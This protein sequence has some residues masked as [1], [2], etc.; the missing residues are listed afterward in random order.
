MLLGSKG[1][2]CEFGPDRN[3]KKKLAYAEKTKDDEDIKRRVLTQST[4]KVNC[5]AQISL[6]E[7]LKF[8]EYP[9]EADTTYCRN[10][11][12]AEL[13]KK[14]SERQKML[15]E[16][17]IYVVLPPAG[18]HSGHTVAEVDYAHALQADVDDEEDHSTIAM[19]AVLQPP[20]W[21]SIWNAISDDQ[22]KGW[23]YTLEDAERVRESFERHTGHTYVVEKRTK[24]FGQLKMQQVIQTDMKALKIRFKDIRD[25]VI[26]YD[27]VPFLVCGQYT[28]N[29]RFGRDRHKARKQREREREEERLRKSDNPNKKKRKRQISIKQGCQAKIEMKEIIRFQKFQCPPHSHH[30]RKNISLKIRD[31]WSAGIPLHIESRIYIRLPLK[32]E[33]QGSHVYEKKQTRARIMQAVTLESIEEAALR[34]KGHIHM[35]PVMTCGMLDSRAQGRKLFFKC[36]LL[37]KTGSFKIRGALNAVVKLKES[38]PEEEIKVVTHSSGNFGQALAYAAKLNGIEA[39]IVMPTT[40]PLCKRNA[41]LGYGAGVVMCEPTEE[42]REEFGKRVVE[43]TGA[44]FFS[45]SQTYDVISG[46]GTIGLELLEQIPDLD[47][48]VVPVGGGGM[49]AGIATAIKSKKPSIKVYAAEPANANDC[50]KSFHAKKFIPLPPGPV[51]TVADGLKVSIGKSTWPIIANYVDDVF[52]VTEEEIVNATCLVWQYMKQWIEPS[53]GVGVAV[54]MSENF[55]LLPPEIKNVAVILCGGNV[56]MDTV[57]SWL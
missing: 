56:D 49:I 22:L 13:R 37:Q 47:A 38:R 52:T 33:H 43:E 26:P 30:K 45:P 36:E 9:V 1:L 10:T 32:S 16:R 41:V 19:N 6:F 25:A 35:T 28:R 27:G 21:S 8:P 3:V 54:V 34:V 11:T 42:S 40:A 18:S 57:K 50:F 20:H 2:E 24:D 39:F 51:D 12:S 55:S 7:V 17:R 14:L 53:A 4:K 15:Q 31:M 5:G 29:C 48:V 46:Q 44:H 23:V